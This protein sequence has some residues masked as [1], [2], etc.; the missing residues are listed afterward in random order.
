MFKGNLQE[1][2]TIKTSRWELIEFLRK[3]RFNMQ[4]DFLRNGVTS[5]ELGSKRIGVKG[6]KLIAE[7]L[8]DNNFLTKLYLGNSRIGAEGDKVNY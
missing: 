2:T 6:A 8:K 5:L 4:A 3:K 1:V 7:I